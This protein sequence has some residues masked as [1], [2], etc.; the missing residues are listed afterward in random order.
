[1]RKLKLW[2]KRIMG[3]CFS[4]TSTAY[5]VDPSLTARV[6]SVNG[7]LREY[8]VPVIVSD[9]LQTEIAASFL[10]NSDSL[11]YDDFIPAMDSDSQLQAGQIY[12]ALPTFKLQYRL[13][14]SDMAALAVKASLALQHSTTGANRFKKK[15]KARISPVLVANQRLPS[16]SELDSGPPKKSFGVSGSGSI[17][18][19]KRYSSRRA[20]MAARS[21]RMM[22]TTIDEHSVL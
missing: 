6:I 1:M 7:A 8:S 19:L 12:F 3:A 21:F 17:R 14:A 13:T 4:S 5:S 2:T 20:R 15:K 9:V 22:L 16:D 11:Y 10:C 18:K